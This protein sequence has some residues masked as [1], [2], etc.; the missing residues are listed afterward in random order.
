MS[1]AASAR[2]SPSTSRA[3]AWPSV[4]RWYTTTCFAAVA[5]KG[6]SSLDAG[7]QKLHGDENSPLKNRAPWSFTTLSTS[8]STSI[9]P[10]GK[11]TRTSEQII[12]R[13]LRR[14]QESRTLG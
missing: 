6:A 9:H 8:E 7:E 2:P 13:Q 12:I 14:E 5:T 1:P 11:S 4:S 10:P 3:E